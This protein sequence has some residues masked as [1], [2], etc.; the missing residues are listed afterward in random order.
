MRG[1]LR[2]NPVWVSR[3]VYKS[4]HRIVGALH[5]PV[6]RVFLMTIATCPLSTEPRI[7]TIMMR[8]PQRTSRE[9]ISNM[10]PTARSGRLKLTKMCWPEDAMKALVRETRK[11][12][13]PHIYV[14][15]H[16]LCILVIKSW[17]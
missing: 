14:F 15:P 5:I 1:V 13:W 4:R 10:I 17:L 16:L 7:L 9:T 11:L 3:E 8:Q 12:P 6:L 2:I